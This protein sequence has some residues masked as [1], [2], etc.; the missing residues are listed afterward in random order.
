MQNKI[1]AFDMDDVLCSRSSDEGGV[2]KYYTCKPLQKMIDVANFPTKSHGEVIAENMDVRG[3]DILD[4]G[5]GNGHLVRL[6]T[7]MGAIVTGI[8]PAKRQLERAHAQPIIGTES[9]I[10]G[11][12]EKLPVDDESA[13]IIIFFNSLHH[14]PVD[15]LENAFNEARRAIR[16]EGILYIA[17]PLSQGPQFEL[18][19]PFNDETEVRAKAYKAI[20]NAAETGFLEQTEYYYAADVLYSDFDAYRENSTSINPARDYYFQKM[21]DELRRRFENLGEK[22]SDGWH[23]SQPIRVNI[24]K[25]C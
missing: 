5:C 18:A 13:T 9:Y 11:A 19:K 17:E 6:M 12:A 8:D 3:M 15:Q 23:F 22:R 24:L 4:V 20:K 1:I 25:A 21:G 2:E 10:Q 7:E 14:V 16:D